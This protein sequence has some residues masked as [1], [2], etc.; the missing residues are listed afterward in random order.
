MAEPA[1]VEHKTPAVLPQHAQAQKNVGRPKRTPDE[2]AEY[3][4]NQKNVHRL[5]FFS[6]FFLLFSL[7]LMF[8]DDYWGVTPA[9][10]RH[11]KEYQATFSSMELVKLQFEIE[12]VK[13]ELKTHSDRL[14]KVERDIAREEERL[15]DPATEREIEY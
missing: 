9:K 11:W 6:S 8:V 12:E 4:Y 15:A 1:K 14:E 5:M 7:V 2:Q 3:F 10:N 13:K